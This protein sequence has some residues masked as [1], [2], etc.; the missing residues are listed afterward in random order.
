MD[1]HV[2]TLYP[3]MFAAALGS[4]ILGRAQERGLLK[5]HTH[6]IRDFALDKHHSVDHTPYGGGAGM[7]M[8]ADVLYAAWEHVQKLAP[9]SPAYT[10]LLSPQGTPFRQRTA[11]LL[12]AGRGKAGKKFSRLLL[13]CGRF[14]GVDERFIEE[15]VDEESSIGDYVVTGG[16]IPAMVIIDAVGR[17]LPG[18]VGN[19]D[20]L[21]RESFSG[22]DGG[23]LEHPQYTFPREFHGRTVP[24]VLLSG[25][26]ARIE[27]WRRAES[28]VRTSRR[29]PDLIGQPEGQGPGI[30]R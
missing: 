15:C 23:L 2:L 7:V 13:V 3:D 26:H 12:A 5:V 1:F 8:R 28:T 14:E 22:D 25:D 6:Q 18:V 17:L 29:R 30:R 19:A 16:E 27:A 20:S 21:T 9:D 4:S 24:E 10:I 11:E